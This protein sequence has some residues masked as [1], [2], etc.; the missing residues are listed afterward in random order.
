MFACNFN[1]NPLNNSNN[2]NNLNNIIVNSVLTS[3]TAF[4]KDL[5]VNVLEVSN[6]IL[7]DSNNTIDFGLNTNNFNTLYVDDIIL[8]IINND[9]APGQNST[10]TLD[11]IFFK[12]PE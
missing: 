7:P 3:N 9:L 11:N 10:N 6:S 2:S 5:S 8:N 1:K 4:I 12:N